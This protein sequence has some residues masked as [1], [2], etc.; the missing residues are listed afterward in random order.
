MQLLLNLQMA[1]LVYFNYQEKPL[2]TI[3]SISFLF[4]LIS[5]QKEFASKHVNLSV[6]QN[7]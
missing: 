2:A 6:L 1:M 7:E 4:N 5:I 3:Q